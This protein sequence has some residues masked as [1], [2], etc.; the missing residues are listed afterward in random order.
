[1]RVYTGVSTMMMDDMM[2]MC[3]MR[4]MMRAQ[5]SDSPCFISVMGC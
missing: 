1:M 3:G 2:C 5:N 4:T